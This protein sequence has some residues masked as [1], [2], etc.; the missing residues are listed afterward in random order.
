M[1]VRQ[2]SEACRAFDKL[3][4]PLSSKNFILKAMWGVL[5][6]YSCIFL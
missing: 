6:V 5:P 3:K 1:K 2:T 4:A